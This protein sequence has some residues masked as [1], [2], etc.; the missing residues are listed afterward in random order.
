M[1]ITTLPVDVQ[2]NIFAREQSNKMFSTTQGDVTYVSL[3]CSWLRSRCLIWSGKIVHDL[4]FKWQKKT[5]AMPPEY[6]WSIDFLWCG[7]HLDLFIDLD[8]SGTSIMW[9]PLMP[10][11]VSWVK[12]VPTSEASSIPV[13]PICV[14][15]HSCAAQLI[16]PK[17]HY[18]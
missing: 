14:A 4:W 6:F 10:S 12:S 18:R 3:L 17:A 15:T 9:T 5:V 11:K 1:Q 8:Y 7:G 2:E 13:F 16:V